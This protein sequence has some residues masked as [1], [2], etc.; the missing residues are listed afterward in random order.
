[1]PSHRLAPILML[2]QLSS[3][4]EAHQ[5]ILQHLVRLV[6]RAPE[7]HA[8]PLPGISETAKG[9]QAKLKQQHKR[10][11]H[12]CAD[13]RAFVA[14]AV[15]TSQLIECAPPTTSGFMTH[16]QFAI[17]VNFELH[18]VS[19]N[20]AGSGSIPLR[21]LLKGCAEQNALGSFAACGNSY[22][23]IRDVFLCSRPLCTTTTHLP[24][25]ATTPDGTQYYEVMRTPCGECWRHLCDIA[26]MVRASSN[27]TA[28][29][30]LH[31]AS[32][33]VSASAHRFDVSTAEASLR[34]AKWR[35]PSRWWDPSLPAASSARGDIIPHISFYSVK[36]PTSH[37]F[38]R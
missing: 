38:E 16:Q 5:N 35:S 26:R 2:K 37:T 24:P 23:T 9:R 19:L 33:Q 3:L 1:M 21:G 22:D 12:D 29:L 31:I 14:S 13:D 25:T 18:R 36:L 11:S 27:G 17:G 7:E 34:E 6:A 4:P 20:S 10:C 28:Q 8:P 32:V 15:C 30:H